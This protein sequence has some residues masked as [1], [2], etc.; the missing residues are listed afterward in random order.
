MTPSTPPQD[1]N[2][3]TF[4]DYGILDNEYTADR[5]GM[6]NG[7][8]DG[9]IFSGYVKHSKA[10]H[11]RL[12]GTSDASVAAGAKEWGGL[13]YHPNAINSGASLVID[14]SV[15]IPGWY[16]EISAEAIGMTTLID[17]EYFLQQSVEFVDSDNDGAED[18]LKLGVGVNGVM[19]AP[20]AMNN[21]GCAADGYV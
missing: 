8:I 1:L 11:F 13:I 18:D 5:N 9:T 3:I 2:K 10:N 14:G 15:A 20:L 4:R 6:Y 17:A 16:M 19:V 21:T 12:G 7:T